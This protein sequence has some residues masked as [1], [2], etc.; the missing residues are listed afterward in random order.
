M[1]EFDSKKAILITADQS[2]RTRTTDQDVN[3]L[4]SLIVK[5]VKEAQERLY[6]AFDVTSI[7]DYENLFVKEECN[8][9]FGVC[10]PPF[11]NQDFLNINSE[12]ASEMA[13]VKCIKCG[14]K[15]EFLRSKEEM[16]IKV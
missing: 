5:I 4:K 10:E 13:A 2:G 9:H 12:T 15:F 14:E 1:S 6:A 8:H 7:T 16:G 11:S 3:K